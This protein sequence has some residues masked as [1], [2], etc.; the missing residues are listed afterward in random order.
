[1][2]KKQY[3]N[4]WS[5]SY[6]N[7]IFSNFKFLVVH[8]FESRL[9][10][11]INS[12]PIYDLKI[13]KMSLNNEKKCSQNRVM[14]QTFVKI[15]Y[16]NWLFLEWLHLNKSHLPIKANSWSSV[17]RLKCVCQKSRQGYRP[18]FWYGIVRSI[19]L[20]QIPTLIMKYIIS[21]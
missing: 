11:T 13:L 5:T 8:I 9:K 21:E 1:M 7:V 14:N 3:G 2:K 17:T 16:G 18:V 10:W 6:G 15:I 4:L 20:V 19:I 12:P